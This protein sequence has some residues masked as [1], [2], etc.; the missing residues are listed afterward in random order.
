MK[1]HK[2]LCI[3]CALLISA[4]GKVNEAPAEKAA[5][6]PVR[7][8]SAQESLSETS[9]EEE[10]CDSENDTALTESSLS[11]EAVESEA[12]SIITDLPDDLTL[13]PDGAETELTI[14]S[15]TD[16]NTC[17][18]PFIE[19]G[20]EMFSLSGG[21]VRLDDSKY[22]DRYNE[23]AKR[24]MSGGEMP[25]MMW[26]DKTAFPSYAVKSLFQP[27]D[28]IIDFDSELWAE[29]KSA[30]D[31]YSID[32][33]HYAAPISVTPASLL[34]Y[35]TDVAEASGLDD[36]Y[37]LYQN[38]DWNR[39]EMLGL[40]EVFCEENGHYGI[41]GQFADALFRAEGLPVVGYDGNGFVNYLGNEKRQSIADY[42]HDIKTR[43]LISDGSRDN[44]KTALENGDV[45]FCSMGALP[46]SDIQSLAEEKYSLVPMP[47]ENDAYTV[48]NVNAIIWLSGSSKAD[49][50]KTWLDCLRYAA[51]DPDISD[52]FFRSKNGWTNEMIGLYMSQ[53]GFDKPV[54]S[55]YVYG[56]TPQLNIVS[57][58]QGHS[59][60]ELLTDPT[61][62][63]DADNE[64]N[65]TYSDLIDSCLKDYNDLSR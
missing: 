35:R 34:L 22:D 4:C 24:L 62:S 20:I 28:S 18:D 13:I 32:G 23:I 55:E 54:V 3:V 57:S 36:P 41:G 53:T 38:G 6:A 59:A 42:L 46:Y 9:S 27:V 29:T 52:R 21:T 30:A 11:S 47:S 40:M 44:C 56:L 33:A 49:A 65:S 60:A 1:K 2:L 7:E 19:A 50:M 31:C 8:G 10:S 37:E 14:I 61:I 51:D 45:L 5:D 63:D 15:D 16:P 48:G 25:D 58:E 64:F 26:L 17:D 43:G 12:E 39:E